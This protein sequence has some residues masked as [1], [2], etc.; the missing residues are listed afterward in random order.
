YQGASGKWIGPNIMPEPINIKGSYQTHASLTSNGKTIYF[1]SLRK[2]GIGGFDIYKSN[3]KADGS[4]GE[5]INLGPEI[6]TKHDENSPFMTEDGA[7]L[8]FSS[9]GHNSIGGFDI[10]FSKLENKKWESAKNMGRPINSTADDTYYF[11]YNNG[12][13][14]LYSSARP[15]GMGGN[16]IYKITFLDEPE[17]IN[18]NPL[19]LSPE[20]YQKKPVSVFFNSHDT[21]M[22]GQAYNFDGS[23]SQIKD[24]DIRDYFWNMG[25]GTTIKTGST[26]NHTFRKPGTYEV[27]LEANAMHN[28]LLTT[29]NYCVKKTVTV[30]TEEEIIPYLAAIIE[31][32]TFNQQ[33]NKNLIYASTDNI[34]SDEIEDEPL[35]QI[36]GQKPKL[37]Q[38]E[39]VGERVILEKKSTEKY[40]IE[41]VYY[42]LDE[43]MFVPE[44]K[45]ILDNAAKVLHDYPSLIALV[46]GH[47]DSRGNSNYNQ[48]L[49]EKRAQM[50]ANYLV[51]LGVNSSRITSYGRGDQ[52]LLNEC[53]SGVICTD[54]QHRI[55]R[56]SEIQLK[57]S[58]ELSKSK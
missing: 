31:K 57:D 30:L 1:S 43:S 44:S 45:Q 50:V 13:N 51:N 48:I 56:R 29:N 54:E 21:I 33:L 12:K 2:G 52:Q 22:N 26:V 32:E 41:K 10:F 28:K 25:D 36:E 34:H 46:V 8:Y 19:A 16:D 49:S 58:Q 38:K 9:K 40:K 37:L 35:A 53:A 18:C 27:K 7:T 11:P 15:E 42:N 47:A 6:N 17:F 23:I 3:L 5:A 39:I 24:A 4:W 14:A 20:Q 55:N